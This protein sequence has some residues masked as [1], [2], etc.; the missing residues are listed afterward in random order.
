MHAV[1]LYPSSRELDR[2]RHSVEP[3][4]QVRDNRRFVIAEMQLCSACPRTLDEELDGWK[5]PGGFGR[6]SHALR[7]IRQRVQS[8]DVLSLG[9]ERLTARRKDVY[10]WCRRKDRGCESRH[11]FDQMFAGIEDQQNSLIPQI[12]D[13]TGR[14]VLGLHRQSKQRCH[15]GAHQSWIADHAKID[16]QQRSSETLHQPVPDRNRESRLTDAARSYDSH[17]TFCAQPG[18]YLLDFDLAVDHRKTYR[19]IRMLKCCGIFRSRT[20]SG[21]A[22]SL[23]HERVASS[24]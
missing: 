4:T 22:Q 1:G 16:E 23:S 19:Q 24:R 21:C 6:Q 12:G 7:R 3:A 11:G 10:V 2:K 17:E 14:C 8:V 9:L 15:N 18:G 13:N 5:C 20:L